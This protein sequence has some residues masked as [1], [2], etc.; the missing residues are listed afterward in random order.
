MARSTDM[1]EDLGEYVNNK[2]VYYLDIKSS[3]NTSSRY[4]ESF[5]L[6]ELFLKRNLK[7]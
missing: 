7:I 1:D 6:T 4:T 2:T 3:G 5:F